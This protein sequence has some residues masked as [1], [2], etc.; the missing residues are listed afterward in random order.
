[1]WKQEKASSMTKSIWMLM[2]IGKIH[3]VLP[4]ACCC[5]CFNDWFFSLNG[6]KSLRNHFF[7]LPTHLSVEIIGSPSNSNPTTFVLICCVITK[8][9]FHYINC[10]STRRWR[11]PK[12]R[13]RRKQF[14]S[15]QSNFPSLET[16]E[17]P[18]LFGSLESLF[19]AKREKNTRNSLSGQITRCLFRISM[20]FWSLLWLRNARWDVGALMSSA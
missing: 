7:T 3:H 2:V 8:D 16:N 12:K 1:M 4:R 5:C 14:S 9:I 15:H 18:K 20:A 6:E 13:E 17:M 19:D 10:S 11:T